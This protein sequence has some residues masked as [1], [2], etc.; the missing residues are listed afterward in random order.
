MLDPDGRMR[1]S[2]EGE[3]VLMFGKH[4]GR[5][6]KEV[7]ECEPDYLRFVTAEWD[8]FPLTIREL[9]GDA[10]AGVFPIRMESEANPIGPLMGEF[11]LLRGGSWNGPAALSRASS[12]DYA[13]PS[14]R[15]GRIGF[16]PVRTISN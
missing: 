3:A 9:A 12:R 2:D 4:R 11:R 1:W 14:Y 15:L 6:L 13:R 16:R 7:A 8:A 10:L 5:T